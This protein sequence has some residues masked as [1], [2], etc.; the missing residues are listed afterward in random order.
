MGHPRCVEMMTG[1]LDRLTSFGLHCVQREFG[2]SEAQLVQLVECFPNR[3]S[4]GA[5]AEDAVSLRRFIFTC[6]L[7]TSKY[8]SNTEESHH[9]AVFQLLVGM[10][11]ASRES[12]RLGKIN[13]KDG[14]RCVA[15]FYFYFYI[16]CWPIDCHPPPP[17]P[18]FA[19]ACTP[20]K[21]QRWI[22]KDMNQQPQSAT[23]SLPSSPARP[24]REISDFHQPR[25]AH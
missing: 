22:C 17:N 2:N 15:I 23:S 21:E 10:V 14:G 25:H 12:T 6:R 24:G 9:L 5:G 4:L 18:T 19:D 11:G 7:L 8:V 3:K 13:S 20:T 1:S 16:F